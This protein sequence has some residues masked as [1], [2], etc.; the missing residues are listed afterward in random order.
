LSSQA[1]ARIERAEARDTP[2]ILNLMKVAGLTTA[3]LDKAELWV[4]R[5][6]RAWKHEDTGDEGDIVGSVGLEIWGG[7]QGVLRS[8]VVEKSHRNRGLGSI[9]VRHVIQSAKSMGLNEIFLLTEKVASY[10]ERFGF[11]PL[12]RNKVR[13]EVLNSDEFNG[14]CLESATVM[15]LELQATQWN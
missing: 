2:G 11:K 7:K 14:A 12:E 15:R 4:L 10:Y 8:L 3:G 5:E 9:L 6:E 1:S 13:G